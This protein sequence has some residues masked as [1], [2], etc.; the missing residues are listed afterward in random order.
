MVA[1]LV[2]APAS[3]DEVVVSRTTRGKYGVKLGQPWDE[4]W[5]LHADEAMRLAEAKRERKRTKRLRDL[6]RQSKARDE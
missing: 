2:A 3:D 4:L 1:S 5:K 6:Q